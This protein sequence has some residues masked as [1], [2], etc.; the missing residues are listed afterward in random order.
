MGK[1]TFH[2]RSAFRAALPVVLAILF[3]ALPKPAPAF[4]RLLVSIMPA[5]VIEALDGKNRI[6][7]YTIEVSGGRI[8]GF[9]KIPE[10]W[11]IKVKDVE[12]PQLEAFAVHTAAY[13]TAEDVRKG[14]LSDFLIIEARP[15]WGDFDIKADFSIDVY[16]ED[17]ERHL[18]LGKKDMHI[19]PGKAT[20]ESRA[21]HE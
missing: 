14:T 7:E 21:P 5:K 4:D 3:A 6:S 2:S 19:I 18:L 13:M 17:E 1:R 8:Y 20:I 15:D 9:V 11:R 16:M 12:A 10:D